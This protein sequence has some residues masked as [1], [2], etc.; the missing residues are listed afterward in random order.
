MARE[1]RKW[2]RESFRE[3]GRRGAGVSRLRRVQGAAASDRCHG[4]YGDCNWGKAT[5]ACRHQAGFVREG[6]EDVGA[7]DA[8][9]VEQTKGMRR[10]PRHPAAKKDVVS[11]DK[12]GGDA[13]SH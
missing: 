3:R 6:R 13:N 11:C 9:R 12:P 5:V 8:L 1:S 2:G 10:M 4:L 7:G